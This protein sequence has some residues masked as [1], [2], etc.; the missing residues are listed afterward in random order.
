[1][2]DPDIVHPVFV[3]Q[4]L[5]L[6]TLVRWSPFPARFQ[7]DHRVDPPSLVRQG[8]HYAMKDIALPVSRRI[9]LVVANQLTG[10]DLTVEQPHV[11]DDDIRKPPLCIGKHR[12]GLPT[13]EHQ[14]KLTVGVDQIW[15]AG[16]QS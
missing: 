10:R 1:V 9:Q 8:K 3:A 15:Q 7:F 4:K 14:A 6:S 12:Q 13:R 11:S 16:R 2:F 5:T